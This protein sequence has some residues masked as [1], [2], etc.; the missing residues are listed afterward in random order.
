MEQ[1][2]KKNNKKIIVICGIVLLVIVLLAVFFTRFNN[3]SVTK[4][5]TNMVNNKES[6]EE[7]TTLLKD[8]VKIGDYVVY[9]SIEEDFTMTKNETGDST[10]LKFNTNEYK[11]NWRAMYNDDENGLQIISTTGVTHRLTLE[12][13]FGYNNAVD[14][15]N[16]FCNHY[17]NNK[18]YAISGRC[19]GS[20][21][22]S[23]KDSAGTQEHFSAGALKVADENY[24]KDLEVINNNSL[25]SGGER[26]LLA[27]RYIDQKSGLNN[28]YLRYITSSGDLE[29]NSRILYSTATTPEIEAGVKNYYSMNTNKGYMVSGESVRAIITLKQ[30]VKVKGGDGTKDNP[31]LLAK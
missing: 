29:N 26:T 8:V 4:N 22:T 3:M 23:S 27:S 14:T 10:D 13:K 2:K 17:A 1:E 28:Y 30:D 19:L 25:H 5:D 18:D 15:L 31:Y 12:G 16:S 9:E 7:Y 20:N 21:P 11:D 24:R 6:K